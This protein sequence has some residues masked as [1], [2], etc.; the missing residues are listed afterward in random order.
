MF[1]CGVAVMDSAWGVRKFFTDRYLESR[2]QAQN[3]LFCF[4]GGWGGSPK[5][6]RYAAWATG[7]PNTE[8]NRPS[9]T[10]DAVGNSRCARISPAHNSPIGSQR[11][12][13]RERVAADSRK[14]GHS[15]RPRS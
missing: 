14:E 15:N 3:A 5:T 1:S 2:C 7:G 12:R 11:R 13:F 10:R 6:S 8:I 9:Q 4:L